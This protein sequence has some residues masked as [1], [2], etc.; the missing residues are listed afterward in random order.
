MSLDPSLRRIVASIQTVLFI[1]MHFVSDLFFSDW[2]GG[3]CLD[4]GGMIERWKE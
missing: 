1:E 2:G 3:S 4:G